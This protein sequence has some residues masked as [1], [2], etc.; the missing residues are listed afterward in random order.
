MWLG[1]TRKQLSGSGRLS[2]LALILS[3][4]GDWEESEWREKLQAILDGKE[5]PDFDLL[6][7]I[8][9]VLARPVAGDE[10]LQAQQDLF[11]REK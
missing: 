3:R 8:D 6:T 11:D 10:K 9:S 7:R 5:E 2:E 1:R 4:N